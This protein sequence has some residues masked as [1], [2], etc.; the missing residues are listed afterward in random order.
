MSKATVTFWY[1]V[2]VGTSDRLTLPS[3]Q[4]GPILRISEG[5]ADPENADVGGVLTELLLG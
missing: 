5:L 4:T 2:E 3:G 1:P